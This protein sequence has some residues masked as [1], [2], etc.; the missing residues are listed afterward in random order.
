MDRTE[1]TDIR[2][3]VCAGAA[4]VTVEWTDQ[5]F[6]TPHGEVTAFRCPNGCDVDPGTM[7]TM[8]GVQ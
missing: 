8:I 3:P 1:T 5:G 4:K 2:C 6:D 7:R